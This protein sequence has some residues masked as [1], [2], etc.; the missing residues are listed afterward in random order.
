VN[1]LKTQQFELMYAL[2]EEWT[3]RSLWGNHNMK[4]TAG[5]LGMCSCQCGPPEECNICGTTIR[6]INLLNEI[7]GSK[8]REI[9]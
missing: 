8:T 2:L 7:D 4:S 3:N 9:R 6:S 5:H 1:D